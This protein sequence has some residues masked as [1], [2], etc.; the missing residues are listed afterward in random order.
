M[1]AQAGYLKF[2]QLTVTPAAIIK[3]VFISFELERKKEKK[4]NNPH[5]KEIQFLYVSCFIVNFGFM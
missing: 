4:K 1:Q 2:K 3:F 5:L